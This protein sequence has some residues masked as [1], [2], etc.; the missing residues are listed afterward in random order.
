MSTVPAQWDLH[1]LPENTGLPDNVVAELVGSRKPI[2]FVEGERGSL[3]LTIYGSHYTNFTL[4]PIG[5]CDNV[6]HSV[7]TYKNSATLH[8]LVVRGLVDADDRGSDDLAYLQA[9]HIYSLPVAEIE[10]IFSLPN[11]FLAL[12]KALMCTDPEGLLAK[13]KEDV[14]R[15]ASANIDLVSARHSAR[16]IDRKLKMIEVEAKNA[17]TLQVAFQDKV[18]TINPTVIFERFRSRLQSYIDAGDLTGVMKLYDNKGILSLVANAL[19]LKNQKILLERVTRLINQDEGE[20]LRAGLRQ[21]H[22][23]LF[24]CR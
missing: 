7:T 8:W 16:Q 1:E 18:S 11:I 23:Q 9:R 13:L 24:H 10:N 12:A 15:E 21:K 2:L 19:G 4:V 5:S 22:F 17:Q 20:S 14:L 6:L 3:D